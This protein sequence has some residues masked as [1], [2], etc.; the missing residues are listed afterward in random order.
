VSGFYFTFNRRNLDKDIPK[1]IRAKPISSVRLLSFIRFLRII[2]QTLVLS[3]ILRKFPI[4]PHINAISDLISKEQNYLAPLLGV[5]ADSDK[6]F[7][8]R[9]A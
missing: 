9:T 3:D 7:V 1:T 5:S 6:A 8:N 2:L 4:L